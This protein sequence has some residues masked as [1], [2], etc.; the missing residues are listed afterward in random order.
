MEEKVKTAVSKDEKTIKKVLTAN[1]Y[2]KKIR[3]QNKLYQTD[4]AKLLGCSYSHYVKVENG[5]TKPS[6]DL[7]V[8]I[9]EEFP[10]IDLNE[11]LKK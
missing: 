6:Y 4:M 11:L 3:K 1:I 5:F 7:L 10:S 2:L 9:K 8:K